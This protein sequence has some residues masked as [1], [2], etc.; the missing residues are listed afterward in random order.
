MERNKWVDRGIY[1]HIN[2]PIEMCNYVVH[3]NIEN[4]FRLLTYLKIKYPSGKLIWNIKERKIAALFLATNIKTIDNNFK[5]IIGLK[6]VEYYE[7]PKYCRLVSFDNLR[8]LFGWYQRSS[9][10]FNNKNILNIRATLGG[11]LYTQVFKSYSRKY[12]R[13]NKKVLKNGSALSFIAPSCKY[14][15]YAQI[16]VKLI[17]KIFQI[18][19]SKAVRL[20]QRAEKAGYLK[21]KKQYI[22]LNNDQ[23]I[24]AMKGR[25][26]R[27]ENNN[28]VCHK[29][30][31]AFQG[32]DKIHSELYF[33]KRKKLKTL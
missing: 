17:S 7:K 33:K 30:K 4:P 23:I 8:Y 3:H 21:V 31:Y 29:G 10:S 26:Y 25:E 28:V 27:S 14:A 22:Y 11:I 12:L 19:I 15:D 9:F 16:S 5:K 13:R 18:S 1:N 24:A 2:A 20:K 6:W 32:I